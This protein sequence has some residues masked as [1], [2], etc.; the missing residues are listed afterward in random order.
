M[1]I[2]SIGYSYP[3]TILDTATLRE[4]CDGR[5]DELSSH[6]GIST[7]RSVVP[8]GVLREE[9]S[10]IPWARHKSS[11]ETPST[12]GAAAVRSAL[13][14][15]GLTIHDIKLLLADTCTPLETCP[16][17]GQRIAAQF[18][19]KNEKGESYFFPVYD[20]TGLAAAFPLHLET[21][22][23]WRREEVPQ[24][25]VSVSANAPTLTST[26]ERAI[27]ETLVGDA[28]VA[29]ILSPT[30][31]GRFAVLDAQSSFDT[32]NGEMFINGIYD[33]T[34]INYGD[35]APLLLSQLETQLHYAIEKHNL[36]PSA[37]H[38]AL[39]T[40]NSKDAREL[41]VSKG[42]QS[43]RICSASEESG[44]SAGS[45]PALSLAKLWDEVPPGD[46]VLMLSS[47]P[48]LSSGVVVLQAV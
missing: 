11:G 37:L 44:Y 22:L 24:Y 45:A 5:Y 2:V 10:S 48:G 19:L 14:K 42:I 25:V 43:A 23:S 32:S 8:V 31:K 20:V 34:R 46:H 17:E 29:L 18:D 36:N 4:P 35:V 9:P 47:G 13:E 1:H 12:L 26:Y 15:A 6:F 27:P 40:L 38:I 21:L 33:A 3:S 39:G 30:I 16:S 28:A 7:L 41:L